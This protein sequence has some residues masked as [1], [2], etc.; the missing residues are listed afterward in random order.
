[1]NRKSPVTVQ[2]WIDALP[3]SNTKTSSTISVCHSPARF[4]RGV[5]ARDA[6][7][8]SDD[9][10]SH[11]SSV[12]SML[13]LRRPDPEAVLLGLGFGPPHSGTNA[14]RIPQ[15][16]LG[17]SKVSLLTNI[18]I[19]KFLEQQGEV[20]FGDQKFNSTPGSPARPRPSTS[21]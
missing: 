17:P 5:F 6:S 21:S 10:S 3:M 4:I 13:E 15:R 2:Q 16:F 14:S 19:N 7:I 1:M 11:C 8:Q 18:D 9:A 12:E 20:Q